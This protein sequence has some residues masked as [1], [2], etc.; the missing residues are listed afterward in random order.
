MTM[1]Q[2]LSAGLFMM[3]YVRDGFT[4]TTQCSREREFCV[5]SHSFNAVETLFNSPIRFEIFAS[6]VS[7]VSWLSLSCSEAILR[8]RAS[9]AGEKEAWLAAYYWSYKLV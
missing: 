8:A 6:K 5:F 2:I 3:E 7:E 1:Q 9:S 4:L